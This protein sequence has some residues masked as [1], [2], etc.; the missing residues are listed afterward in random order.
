M[1]QSLEDSTEIRPSDIFPALLFCVSLARV[2]NTP[3]YF[4]Q[5]DGYCYRRGRGIE[6][7]FVDV[8]KFGITV[9]AF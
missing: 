9:S 2:R 7:L 1:Q 3:V 6:E 4:K 5:T 8:D